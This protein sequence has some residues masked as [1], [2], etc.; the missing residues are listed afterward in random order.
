MDTAKSAVDLLNQA[1]AINVT[2]GLLIVMF[3]VLVMYFIFTVT[4]QLGASNK[5]VNK[6]LDTVGGIQDAI[7][8]LEDTIARTEEI[9]MVQLREQNDILKGHGGLLTGL[10]ANLA[11]NTRIVKETAAQVK[12]AVNGIKRVEETNAKTITEL[13]NY[14]KAS[15]NIN[16]V[17]VEAL[18]TI[19]QRLMHIS[20][21][22][23][24][25]SELKADLR[26]V[27]G[28]LDSNT[29]TNLTNMEG[30]TP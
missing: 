5:L 27:L 28:V 24:G 7:D 15:A 14:A 20:A 29:S 21:T 4:R 13:E 25:I 17:M 8:T 3:F 11:D 18:A 23:D 1:S 6:A 19:S 22:T 16:D 12:E 30:F 10:S 2:L 9:K 26:R